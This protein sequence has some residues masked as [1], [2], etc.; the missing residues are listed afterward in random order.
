MDKDYTTSIDIDAKDTYI[1]N[2]IFAAMKGNMGGK[3]VMLKNNNS[4][5]IMQNNLFFGAVSKKI[6]TQNKALLYADPQFIQTSMINAEAFKLH[7]QS[8][9]KNA[10]VQWDIPAIPGAGQGIF[11]DVSAYPNSDFFGNE[12][13]KAKA[14]CLGAYDRR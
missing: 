1:F 3:Q 13:D 2:N 14:P 5:L 4:D 9:A 7:S 12:I 8:P 6:T 11:K 10:G